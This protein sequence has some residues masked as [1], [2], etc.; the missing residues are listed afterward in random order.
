MSS[1][2][3]R[4]Y[5][6]DGLGH[7]NEAEWFDADDDNA[8]VEWIEKSHPDSRC[9]IWRGTRLVAALPKAKEA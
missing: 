1:E 8:A 7:L 5:R 6:L 3:Y 2:N 4:Y 9:E